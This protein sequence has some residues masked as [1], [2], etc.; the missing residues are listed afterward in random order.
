MMKFRDI[1]FRKLPTPDSNSTRDSSAPHNK[2]ENLSAS[3]AVSGNFVDA[4]NAAAVA[5][6]LRVNALQDPR[7][8]DLLG[9]LAGLELL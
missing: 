3:L 6:H 1:Y 5:A 8:A 7:A 2:V 4:S 9:E